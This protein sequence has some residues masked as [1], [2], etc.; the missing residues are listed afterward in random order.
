MA[1]SRQLFWLVDLT[2]VDVYMF[3]RYSLWLTHTLLPLHPRTVRPVLST[4]EGKL[5]QIL[6]TVPLPPDAQARADPLPPEEHLEQS[7]VDLYAS[8]RSVEVQ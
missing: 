4:A 5:V 8:P 3:Y 6:E 7:R 1:S 2:L